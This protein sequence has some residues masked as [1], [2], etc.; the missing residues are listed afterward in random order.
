MMVIYGYM[1]GLTLKGIEH[2]M[3]ALLVMRKYS[4]QKLDFSQGKN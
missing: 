3:K 2:Y 1:D 4:I